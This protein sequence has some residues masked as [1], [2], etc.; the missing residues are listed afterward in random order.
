MTPASTRH[1]RDVRLVGAGVGPHRAADGARDGQPELEA[2]T[3]PPPCAM[4]AA[5][6]IGRPGVGGE[7]VALD[8]DLLGAH[9]DD[10]AADARRR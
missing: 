2:R 7:P 4:V 6:A 3:G 1:R 10:Q 5:L 9:E 8:A